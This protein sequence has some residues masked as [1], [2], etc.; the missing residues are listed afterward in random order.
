[1]RFG[2]QFEGARVDAGEVENVVHD[3]QQLARFAE[4][5]ARILPL[6]LRPARQLRLRQ[7][8]V[9]SQ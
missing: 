4:N 1:M 9:Q 7:A 2:V 6:L 8:P 3:Q 5:M